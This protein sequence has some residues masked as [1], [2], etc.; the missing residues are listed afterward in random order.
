L[1][2]LPL[3]AVGPGTAAAARAAGFAQVITGER[4]AAALADLIVASLPPS[5][6]IAYLC[7]RPRRPDFE[8]ALAAGGHEVAAIE[9]YE[10]RDLVP[11]DATAR[12]A[13]GGRAVDVALVYSP[14]SARRLCEL[15]VRPPLQ[16]LF[17]S[18]RFACISGAAAALLGAFAPDRIM[19]A[20]QP[21]E[22]ALLQLIL[23]VAIPDR[24]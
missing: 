4:D 14:D 17:V 23:P 8:D 24:L 5:A 9:I 13:L 6:R 11:D 3:F 12:Q 21:S 7:G 16:P 1:K 10:T 22:E 20:A 2:G 19:I 15:A 18:T